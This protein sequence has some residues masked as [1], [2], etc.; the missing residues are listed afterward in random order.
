[1]SEQLKN[2]LNICSFVCISLKLNSSFEEKKVQ[3]KIFWELD[4][5]CFSSLCTWNWIMVSS[6]ISRADFT[7]APIF[8]TCDIA[9]KV[10]IIILLL[11]YLFGFNQIFVRFSPPPFPAHLPA[12]HQACPPDYNIWY[13][14]KNVSDPM[15]EITPNLSS[16]SS[17]T[18]KKIAHPAPD[19][20]DGPI[21]KVGKRHGWLSDQQHHY[22]LKF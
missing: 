16:K 22:L 11:K 8:I 10:D 4:P 18:G 2:S 1:M 17:K 5:L 13:K 3:I 6:S 19:I 14:Y 9:I 7:I 15:I 21:Y 20:D 12:R